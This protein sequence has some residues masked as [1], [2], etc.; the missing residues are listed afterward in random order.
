M[1]RIKPIPTISGNAV[2]LC[3][4][5]YDAVN[6]TALY[7]DN[8]HFDY[9]KYGLKEPPQAFNNTV[10]YCDKDDSLTI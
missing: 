3:V 2:S 5:I 6:Y 1:I 4:E 7:S 9:K 10:S 8:P